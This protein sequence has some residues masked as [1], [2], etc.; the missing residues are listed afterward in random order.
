MSTNRVKQHPINNISH[1]KIISAHSS[2]LANKGRIA[3]NP[4]KVNKVS[5]IHTQVRI[6]HSK[7]NSDVYRSTHAKIKG[8]PIN[9][10][11]K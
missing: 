11:I 8:N 1:A 2:A 7:V 5:E 10:L 6:K 9:P 4:S 3:T